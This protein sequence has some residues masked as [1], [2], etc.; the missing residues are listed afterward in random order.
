MALGTPYPTDEMPVEAD[1]LEMPET[2]SEVG[3]AGVKNRG[4]AGEMPS[5]RQ[6]GD[7]VVWS[8]A[9]GC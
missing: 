3:S 8:E 2:I 5:V 7:Q 4:D 6:A 1:K 9:S